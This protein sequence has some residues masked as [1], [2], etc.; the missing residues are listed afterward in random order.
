M[1]GFGVAQLGIGQLA[2]GQADDRRVRTLARL[3]DRDERL[4]DHLVATIPALDSRAGQARF[5]QDL[6]TLQRVGKRE[7]RVLAGLGV[8]SCDTSFVG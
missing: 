6:A 4:L 1:Q 7:E 2:G 5:E 3:F 8:R